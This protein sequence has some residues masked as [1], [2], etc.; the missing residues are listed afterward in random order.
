MNESPPFGTT[1]GSV[2]LT[3]APFWSVMTK[4]K[5]PVSADATP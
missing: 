5:I 2:V 3:M 4:V 1:F